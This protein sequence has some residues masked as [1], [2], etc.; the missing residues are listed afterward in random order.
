MNKKSN[1]QIIDELNNLNYGWTCIDPESSWKNGKRFVRL[2]HNISKEIIEFNYSAAQ[3]N[4]VLFPKYNNMMIVKKLNSLNYGWTCIDPESS[5]KKGRRYVNLKHNIS[6]EIIECYYEC[7]KNNQVNFP[8]YNNM[9]IVKK[10]N[11]LNYGWICI[12]PESGRK[13]GNRLVKLKHK[14]SK[15][16]IE[17][18]YG[19]AKTNCIRFP[20]Y[21]TM[22]REKKINELGKKSNPQYICVSS[23][24]GISN[25]DI[26]V[27]IKRK[28]GKGKIK[29]SFMK[30]LLKG[31][32]P[33]NETQNRVEV[34]MVQ[35]MYEKEFRKNKI[36]FIKEYCLGRKRI[37]YLLFPKT[38]RIGLEVKQS[39]KLYYSGKDQIRK[40][41]QLGSLKQYKLSKVLLSDPQGIHPN[42]LSMN[43]IMSLLKKKSKNNKKS[44]NEIKE[45]F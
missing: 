32:N 7:A 37:D 42:S 5:W 34:N 19:A 22:M 24:C 2:K 35:P 31:Q 33:F 45:L 17:C 18:R 15:E 20:K 3:K 44:F 10:L 13:Q 14:I 41:K 6:K 9:M 16:I 40:Y 23:N 11:S 1:Q 4:E 29:K 21:E 26:L 25:R 27:K 12:D 36:P 43:K 28:D 30:N 8:K 39:G 38:L